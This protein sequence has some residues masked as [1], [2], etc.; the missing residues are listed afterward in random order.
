M[1]E[2]EV[3]IKHLWIFQTEVAHVVVDQAERKASVHERQAPLSTKDR[4]QMS[5]PFPCNLSQAIN[6]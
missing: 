5:E 6:F 2:E 4:Q 3:K 1:S